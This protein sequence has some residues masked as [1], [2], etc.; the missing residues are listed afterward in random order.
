[1]RQTKSTVLRPPECSHIPCVVPTKRPTA[2]HRS[3]RVLMAHFRRTGFSEARCRF[4][5]RIVE[6]VDCMIRGALR[7]K[8]HTRCRPSLAA[9]S[10]SCT[11][12]ISSSGPLRQRFIEDRQLRN[13][14]P[15]TIRHLTKSPATRKMPPFGC[16]WVK[17]H[18]RRAG[19]QA[20]FR[21][22][23]PSETGRKSVGDSTSRDA[24][25]GPSKRV[26]GGAEIPVSDRGGTSAFCGRSVTAAVGRDP[27]REPGHD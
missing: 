7:G 24:V 4:A 3:A 22:F 19:G 27:G 16:G 23:Y 13:R 6:R 8:A 20:Y 14:S 5:S 10:S 17:N 26:S 12:E 2:G 11:R 15:R 21:H 25:G 1:M 18:V 9:R